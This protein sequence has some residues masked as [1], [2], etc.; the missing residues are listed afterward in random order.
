MYNISNGL[1][2]RHWYST[3]TTAYSL[4]AIS[5]FIGNDSKVDMNYQLIKKKCIFNLFTVI[6]ELL[7]AV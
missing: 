7:V 5:K 2:S 4:M 6:T 3:Q 1:A